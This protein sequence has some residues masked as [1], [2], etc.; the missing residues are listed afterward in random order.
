MIY[1]VIAIESG[2]IHIIKM[3]RFVNAVIKHSF[4]A[5]FHLNTLVFNIVSLIWLIA[6][7]YI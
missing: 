2:F 6:V 4:R 1:V 7:S 5:V 3:Y